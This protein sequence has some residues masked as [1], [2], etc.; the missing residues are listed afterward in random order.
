MKRGLVLFTALLLIVSLPVIA[1]AQGM[2]GFSGAPLF[3]PPDPISPADPIRAFTPPIFY[4]GWME[5][6]KNVTF[7]FD[8]AG[9]GNLF[10]GDHRWPVAG[11]WLGLE[12]KVNLSQNL[13]AILDG[14]LLVPTRRKGSEPEEVTRTFVTAFSTT[15][16]I[17]FGTTTEIGGREWDTDP[18][19]WYIDAMG[20]FGPSAMFKVLGGFRYEHFSTRF[21]NPVDSIAVPS[22]PEDRADITVN[23]YQ[24]FVGFQ[25]ATGGP[26]GHISVRLIGFPLVPADVSHRESGEAGSGTIVK[27][28]GNFRSSYFWELFAQADQRFFGDANIGAFFR[29]NWLHGRAIL[30]SEVEPGALASG[31]DSASFDRNTVTVGGSFSLNF[32]SPL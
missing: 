3:A 13:S 21:K 8:G 5:T 29:W 31:D 27:S 7:A 19:W 22:T 10:G 4:I 2:F 30:H 23:S 11:L 1:N 28:I 9:A 16:P 18:D 12:E 26:T 15:V 14:W 32:L 25:Y 20:V 17:A 24:P 6:Y